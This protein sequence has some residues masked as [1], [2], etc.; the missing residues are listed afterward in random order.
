MEINDYEF[1]E[2]FIHDLGYLLKLCCMNHT[3]NLDV[4]FE[5]NGNRLNVNFTFNIPE[6]D[7]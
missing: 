2:G 1:S 3:D 7:E 6:D 4:G 5:F